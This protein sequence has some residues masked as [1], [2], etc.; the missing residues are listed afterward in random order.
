MPVRV[1]VHGIGSTRRRVLRRAAPGSAE[2]SGAALK[3][4]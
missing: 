4:I 2:N 1:N 3:N